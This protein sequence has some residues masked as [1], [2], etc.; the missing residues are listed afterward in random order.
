[1]AA[2]PNDPGSIFQ[3]T[4]GSIM[5]AI[6]GHGHESTEMHD[7]ERKQKSLSKLVGKNVSSI[8]LTP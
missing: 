5:G 8:I 2:L 1:L 4:Y 7:D 6:D 3:Q